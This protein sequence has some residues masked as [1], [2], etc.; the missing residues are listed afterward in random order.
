MSTLYSCIGYNRKAA[1]LIHCSIESMLPLI[2]QHRRAHLFKT[3]T[4]HDAGILQ[5][6]KQMCCVYGVGECNIYADE[7][8]DETEKSSSGMSNSSVRGVKQ[9]RKN[10]IAVGWPQLQVDVLKQCIAVSEALLD[11]K[12]QLYYTAILL[13]TL[14]Q[15]ISKPEQIRLATSIQAM[16][17]TTKKKA[18][19]EPMVNYWGV[20]IISSIE[21]KESIPRKAIYVHSIHH[22]ASKASKDKIDDP[23]IYNPF[24]QKKEE[25][26]LYRSV[27]RNVSPSNLT[28][29]RMLCW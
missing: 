25:K 18:A 20:N 1:W 23:F 6:T 8:L 21:P 15:H 29:I 26:V 5:L 27:G 14:Y 3:N 19:V 17:S 11:N 16:T 24:A 28:C 4:R 7:G 2:I 12:S 13:K 10:E 22:E 9:S